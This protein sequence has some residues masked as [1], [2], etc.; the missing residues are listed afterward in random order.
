[1]PQHVCT[2]TIVTIFLSQYHAFYDFIP[3]YLH[4]IPHT[5]YITGISTRSVA[6]PCRILIFPRRLLL[7]E[8]PRVVICYELFYYTFNGL[9]VT[10]TRAM[11]R[12]YSSIHSLVITPCYSI[13]SIIIPYFNNGGPELR[14]I[15]ESKLAHLSPGFPRYQILILKSNLIKT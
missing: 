11:R 10:A 5:M 12:C 1:M 13:G 2:C 14:K 4:C 6:M 15:W 3:F 8:P 7:A 9:Q